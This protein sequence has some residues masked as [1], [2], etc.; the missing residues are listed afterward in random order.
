MATSTWRRVQSASGRLSRSAVQRM[1]QLPWFAALPAQHRADV[2]LVVQAGLAAF[3][4]WLK[5]GGDASPAPE[6]F[7]AAPRELARSVSLKQTVQLI[8]V[9]VAVLEEEAPRLAA[10]GEGG[11]LG[12]QVLRYSREIAFAAAEV[13]ATAAE[14]R[15]AWDARVE[16]GVVEALVRGQVGELTRSRATSLGWVTGRWVTALASRAPGPGDTS[17][18]LLRAHARY[19][20]LSL[21][22]GE[23][24]GGLLVVLSGDDDP[25]RFVARVAAEL[26]PGPV[27][28]GPF[29]PDLGA[30]VACVQEALAGL[31]AAPAWPDAPR[32]VSSRQLLAERVVLGDESAR[33]RLLEEIH[34]PLVD[35]GG[36]LLETAAAFLDGGGS[37]EGTARTLFVH[38]NTVRYRLK[39]IAEMVSYDLLTPRDAHVVRLAVVLGRVDGLEVTDKNRP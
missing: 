27:V 33:R 18:E 26:P 28:V 32:P 29:A 20:G 38:P 3:T 22:S 10:P 34:K 8:R 35:A 24:H 36:D 14:A 13:Y 19:H 6:V 9:V 30:A 25:D 1:E 15:G 7:A 11:L 23:A 12:E 2:G 4:T 17:A 37:V 5:E 31:A 16:A 39:R 21:L